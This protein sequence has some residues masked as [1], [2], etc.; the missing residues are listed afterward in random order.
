MTENS[1]FGFSDLAKQASLQPKEA[2]LEKMQPHKALYIGV[3]KEITLQEHRIGLTP[4]SVQ[5]LVNNGN[6]VWIET[7]AGKDSNFSDKEY[8]EAGAKICFEK[9]EI[10]KAESF[11]SSKF[12]F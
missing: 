12:F 7:N 5:Q 9:S 3:P 10:F 2:L 4:S 6:E 1:S 11:D 8:S